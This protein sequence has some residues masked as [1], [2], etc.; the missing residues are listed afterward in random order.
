MRSECAGDVLSRVDPEDRLGASSDAWATGGVLDDAPSLYIWTNI[1]ME[2]L[3]GVGW[4]ALAL[5][6]FRWL[7]EGGRNDGS[8]E[9][10]S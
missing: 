5:A 10:G 2:V 7:A 8:I 1:R 3:V 4:L 6:S 9:F